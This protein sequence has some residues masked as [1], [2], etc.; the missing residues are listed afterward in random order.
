MMQR[1][2]FGMLMGTWDVDVNYGIVHPGSMFDSGHVAH[3]RSIFVSLKRFYHI[4]GNLKFF[5]NSNP[6]I[7]LSMVPTSFGRPQHIP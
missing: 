3:C 1:M 4:C 6:P 5:L 2:S 7:S